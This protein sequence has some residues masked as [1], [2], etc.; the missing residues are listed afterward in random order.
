VSVSFSDPYPLGLCSKFYVYAG[1]VNKKTIYLTTFLI[2]AALL[3]IYI[4]NTIRGRYRQLRIRPLTANEQ[5]MKQGAA[6]E[7]KD[8]EYYKLSKAMQKAAL[9]TTV[10][11]WHT[12]ELLP[13]EDPPRCS[14]D[15]IHINIE[16]LFNKRTSADR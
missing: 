15:D 10:D 1:E 16:E 3:F 14:P 2:P 7:H 12:P 8:M 6:S 4:F 5:E 9:K 13:Y 11:G